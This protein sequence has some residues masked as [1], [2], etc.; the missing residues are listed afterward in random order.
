M[1]NIRKVFD[2]DPKHLKSIEYGLKTFGRY[3][4]SAENIREVFGFHAKIRACTQTIRN[5]LGFGPEH[6][7][8]I[9]FQAKIFQKNMTFLEN[10]QKVLKFYPK[11]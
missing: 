6:S 9:E 5:V 8:G 11:H 1:Q 10:I 3:L 2:F 7:R 4:I